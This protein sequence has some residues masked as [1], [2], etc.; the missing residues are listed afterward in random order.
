MVPVFQAPAIV[1]HA[2]LEEE[3]KMIVEEGWFH[4]AGRYIA[5]APDADKARRTEAER[6]VAEKERREALTCAFC[7]EP[8]GGHVAVVLAMR[9]VHPACAKEFDRWIMETP[10]QNDE[11][12]LAVTDDS[13]VDFDGETL[14]WGDLMLADRKT[15]EMQ[16]DGRLVGGYPL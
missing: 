1:P 3:R 12:W 6:R 16:S 4:V 2:V 5:S 11:R 13:L 10:R 15:V 9:A 14:R 7:F 8:I